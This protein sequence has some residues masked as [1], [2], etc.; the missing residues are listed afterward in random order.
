MR[1]CPYCGTPVSETAKFCQECGAD[2]RVSAPEKTAAWK[3]AE[4]DLYTE[5]EYGP[6]SFTE[7]EPGAYGADSYREEEP[8]AYRSD[9]YIE[10]PDA[11]EHDSY[12]EEEPEAVKT[13]S[14][15]EE[16]ESYD[17]EDYDEEEEERYS[18]ENRKT[19]MVGVVLG[20]LICVVGIGLWIVVSHMLKQKPEIDVGAG[21]NNKTVQVT[22]APENTEQEQT[23]ESGE[24]QGEEQQTEEEQ[25]SLQAAVTAQAPELYGV[26]APAGIAESLESSVLVEGS[27]YHGSGSMLDGTETT[28]WQEDSEGDGTGEWVQVQLDREYSVRYLTFKMGNW[29]SEQLFYANNRPSQIL[30]R[31]DDQEVILDFPDGMNTYTVELSGDCPVSTVYLQVLAVYKGANWDDCCISDMTVY[32]Y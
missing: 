3:Q 14:Y 9:S 10:E 5:E 24:I 13:A 15:M 31:L 18:Q 27:V 1:R 19:V 16:S 28:S 29:R 8:E 32:G 21:L 6:E 4:S 26:Y 25:P 11:Y 2:L 20:A 7:E 12:I 22:A 30:L 17:S 23:E